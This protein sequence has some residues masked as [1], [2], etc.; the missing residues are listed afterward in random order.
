[1]ELAPLLS[2]VGALA[3]LRGLADPDRE[4]SPRVRAAAAIALA[5][6]DPAALLSILASDPDELPRR[7]ALE[8]AERLA[9]SFPDLRRAVEALAVAGPSPEIIRL[10]AEAAERVQHRL[11]PD[12]ADALAAAG[13]ARSLPEGGSV[14]LDGSLD[15]GVLGRALAVLATGDL[16]LA[17]ARSEG[18]WVVTRGDR[19]RRRLWRALHELRH[20]SPD[21]RQSHLHTVGRVVRGEVRAPPG[22]LAEVTATKVPGERVVVPGLGDWGRHL[23]TVDDLLDPPPGGEARVFSAF[24]VTRLAWP[25]GARWR[26]ARARLT[27]GYAEY[28]RLRGLSLAG[29]EPRDRRAYASALRRLGFEIGFTPHRPG[30]PAE[31][32]ALYQGEGAAA[33]PGAALAAAMPVAEVLGTWLDPAAGSVNHLAAAAFV[34]TGLFLLRLHEARRAI[35]RARAAIP[36]TVGGWGTR[37]KS[38]TER[39]KAAL[40]HGL[41]CEVLVKTTGCEAMFIHGVPGLPACEVFIYRA[42]DKA[43]VWEQRDL[44]RVAERL[45]VDVFLWECMALS[46]DLVELLQQ[47]WM[48]DDLAT[49]TNAYPDHENLQGP[50]GVD[51]PR[52]MARFL[53][54]GRPLFTA[55]EQMLPIL[56]DAAL[57]GG[58]ELVQVAWRDH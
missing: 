41:G 39:L 43:T 5:G 19:L 20:P 50:A 45:G 17:A 25:R 56:R 23:P 14:P 46:T 53:P 26:E 10:A 3:A 58:T 55:E 9:P 51:I 12:A 8:E 31:V 40:F 28:A 27:L 35:E 47:E 38:G 15:A 42:Y 49:L 48:R 37:G 57:Q 1:M 36:L 30:G 54:P 11:D 16:P 7:A 52:V 6:R 24:G 2:A 22:G 44:L 33:A 29:A 32:L 18:G 34:A 13:A 4:G 21:K